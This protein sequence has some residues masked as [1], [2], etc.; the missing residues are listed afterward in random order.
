MKVYKGLQN[1]PRLI[2]CGIDIGE[3]DKDY[4]YKMDLLFEKTP[5]VSFIKVT[6]DNFGLVFK[7]AITC[8]LLKMKTN[9][10]Q[11]IFDKFQ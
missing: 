4:Q 9:F 1:S 5:D 8:D 2:L 10:A 7:T 11:K 3:T 6:K